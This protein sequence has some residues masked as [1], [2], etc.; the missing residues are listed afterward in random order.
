MS[1]AVGWIVS[2]SIKLVIVAIMACISALQL[3]QVG[4]VETKQKLHAANL[5]VGILMLVWLGDLNGVLGMGWRFFLIASDTIVATM[6]EEGLYIGYVVTYTSYATTKFSS[7]L[8]S[9]IGCGFVFVGLVFA[10]CHL[11]SVILT[12]ATDNYRFAA[13]RHAAS[14]FLLLFVSLT[15]STLILKLKRLLA[16]LTGGLATPICDEEEG[17]SHEQRDKTDQRVQFLPAHNS[18]SSSRCQRNASNKNKKGNG[19]AYDE[20]EEDNHGLSQGENR[21]FPSGSRSGSRGGLRLSGAD[22]KAWGPARAKVRSSSL[23]KRK[24]SRGVRMSSGGGVNIEAIQRNLNKILFCMAP[25]CALGLASLV[26]LVVRAE[27]THESYSDLCRKDNLNYSIKLDIIGYWS[28]IGI[29]FFLIY[30]A[31]VPMERICGYHLN[32]PIHVQEA[33]IPHGD[34]DDLDDDDDFHVY[35]AELS[36]S[37]DEVSKSS[38]INGSNGS[39]G[40]AGHHL[41]SAENVKHCNEAEG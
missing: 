12:V 24:N 38:G 10:L 22:A 20:E 28:V 5:F 40:H 41:L 30:Y 2:D 37:R 11:A 16:S 39:N 9:I 15:T 14:T 25:V 32:P 6:A 7:R 4:S 36:V 3:Q 31:F 19:D 35:Q 13:L 26:I 34:Y 17:W 29:H 8:P 27:Y 1:T 21:S 33:S 18:D 23:S